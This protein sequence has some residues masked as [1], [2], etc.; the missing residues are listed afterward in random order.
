MRSLR[1]LLLLAAL[2][3]LL[4]PLSGK[5]LTYVDSP[6]FAD[7][8]AAGK[9]PPVAERLPEHPRITNVAAMGRQPGRHGGDLRMLIG[10]AK[11]VRLM[12]VYGYARLV[13]YDSQYNIVP[14]ILEKV[15]VK[16][17]RKFILTL[18]K[19]HRWSDGEPFTSEDFRYWWEDV[20]N[21]AD[22]SPAGPPQSLRIRG[23]LPKVS[24]PDERTIIYEWSRPNPFFLPSLAGTA[25]L[26]IYRPAHYLKRF[27][28]RY[29][30]PAQLAER[31][32]KARARNWA[33]LHNRL[34]N[35][36]KFDNPDLPTLQPWVNRTRPPAARYIGERNPYFHRVDENGLQLPY[37]DRLVLTQVSP[38]LIPVQAGGG[39][40]DL[41]AAGLGFPTYPFLKGNE[42]RVGYKV[43]LWRTSRGAHEAL[44]PN[45]NVSD[46]DWRRLFRDVRFRRALSLGIDRTLINESIYFGLALEGN[47]GVLPDSPLYDP[48]LFRE[49]AVYDPDRANALLDEMGLRERD[50]AGIRLMPGGRPLEIIVET[51]GEDTEQSDILELIG[52]TWREI[53]IKLYIKPIQRTVFRNRI[54]SGLSQMAIWSGLENGLPTP[55]ASPAELAPTSQLGL[56]WPKWGQYYETGG[57]AGEPPDLPEAKALLDLYERWIVSTASEERRAIWKRM[58][59]IH[60]EQQFTIGI[61]AGVRQP[62]LI[63]NRL[64]NVPEEGVYN[65]DPGALFGI[66]RVDTFWIDQ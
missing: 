7:E 35:Q 14:D 51:A 24:F 42:E 22:L 25:P 1:G 5:A 46:P 11:D 37:I 27:H 29:A 33:S 17:G 20:A 3:L 4:L 10:R 34:D 28:A 6:Y 47:N 16:E 36:Y 56:Q 58:L 38:A 13:T 55:D 8:V 19:G 66:Y 57:K 48:E 50:G 43:R 2:F 64:R 21:N 60:A 62:I 23:E 12:M 40:V 44:F 31:V 26:F 53:G 63:S 15:T 39:G 49:W 52:E 30:D 9:L 41:Q 59:A 45:L 54:F 65:W 32:R 61:I 18:R